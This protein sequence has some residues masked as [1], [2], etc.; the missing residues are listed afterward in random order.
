K[1]RLREGDATLLT[2]LFGFG[3]PAPHRV[4]PNGATR[5]WLGGDPRG[6]RP[7]R[8]AN[9]LS[10]PV[11]RRLPLSVGERLARLGRVEI[12]LFGPA[13]PLAGW[14]EHLLETSP[15]YAGE[16][17]ARIDDIRPAA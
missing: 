13:A 14:P 6:P 17:V 1:R 11:G 4:I 7:V 10:A 3:W 9:R 16:T 5:R 15:L 8:A 12:P 2:E